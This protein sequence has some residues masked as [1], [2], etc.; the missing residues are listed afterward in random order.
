MVQHIP[1]DEKVRAKLET[2]V[3]LRRGSIPKTCSYD[4]PKMW[5]TTSESASKRTAARSRVNKA[6][7]DV[8]GTHLRP[9]KRTPSLRST[10]APLRKSRAMNS[11]ATATCTKV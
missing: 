1:V 11:N 9:M 3:H 4:T 8:E 7:S 5:P 10:D 2:H 6:K